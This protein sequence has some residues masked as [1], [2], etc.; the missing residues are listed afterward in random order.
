MKLTWHLATLIWDGTLEGGVGMTRRGLCSGVLLQKAA[1]L[2]GALTLVSTGSVLAQQQLVSNIAQSDATSNPGRSFDNTHL[3]Q[4][5]T[6]GPHAGGYWL[7]SVGLWMRTSSGTTTAA[8]PTV[9]IRTGS[10]TGT[11]EATLTGPSNLPTISESIEFERIFTPPSSLLLHPETTYWIRAEANNQA[12]RWHSTAASAED[13]VKAP[14]WSIA[15]KLQQRVGSATAFSDFG[16]QRALKIRIKGRERR[17]NIPAVGSPV[18]LG[19]AVARQ[20]LS[21]NAFDID[22]ENGLEN[23]EDTGLLVEWRTTKGT[24]ASGRDTFRLTD[25][26]VGGKIRLFIR[27]RDDDG[28]TEEFLTAEYPANG[29]VRAHDDDT[30]S[31]ATGTVTLEGASLLGGTVPVTGDILRPNMDSLVDPDGFNRNQFKFHWI[32]LTPS[33]R[34][35]AAEDGGATPSYLVV[36]DDVGTQMLIRVTTVDEFGNEGVFESAPTEPVRYDIM[37]CRQPDRTGRRVIWQNTVHP[38]WITSGT[39]LTGNLGTRRDLGYDGSYPGAGKLSS[40]WVDFRAGLSQE[41]T[42]DGVWLR[43]HAGLFLVLASGQTLTADDLRKLRLHVCD[44]PLALADAVQQNVLTGQNDSADH[45]SGYRWN[46][47]LMDWTVEDSS[48]EGGI[49]YP[50]TLWLTVPDAP[51]LQSASAN[52]RYVTLAFDPARPLAPNNFPIDPGTAF[53]LALKDGTAPNVVTGIV[54]GH[55]VILTLD[56]AVNADGSGVYSLSYTRPE[57]SLSGTLRDTDGI[58][59]ESFTDKPVQNRSV[60]N[61][62]VLPA[63]SE[64]VLLSNLNLEG[65][66]IGAVPLTDR[67]DMTQAFVTGGHPGGYDLTGIELKLYNALGST[68]LPTVTLYSGSATGMEVATFSGPTV[69]P[70]GNPVDILFTPTAPVAVAPGTKYWVVVEDKPGQHFDWAFVNVTD[71]DAPPAPGWRR[72]GGYGTRAYFSILAFTYEAGLYTQLAIHG[73][74]RAFA[75]GEGT[76][77]G[78][79]DGIRVEETNGEVRVHWRPPKW[80]RHATSYLLYDIRYRIGSGEW[81]DGPQGVRGEFS[82]DQRNGTRWVVLPGVSSTSNLEVQVTARSTDATLSGLTLED[83]KGNRVAL[84]PGFSPQ[85]ESYGAQVQFVDE[86]TITP[87]KNH[88]AAVLEILDG[89]GATLADA[90]SNKTGHQVTL[91]RTQDTDIRIRVTSASTNSQTYTVTVRRVPDHCNLADSTEIWCGLMTVG[92]RRDE[93]KVFLGFDAEDRIGALWPTDFEFR[94]ATVSVSEITFVS[95]GKMNLKFVRTAGTTPSNGLLGNSL[96]VLEFESG[97][98]KESV[99]FDDK[100]MTGNLELNKSNPGLS[101]GDARQVKLFELP[102]ATLWRLEIWDADDAVA[103]DLSPSFSWYTGTYSTSVRHAVDEITIALGSVDSMSDTIEYFDENG[104]AISDENSDALAHQVALSV[105]E[106]T[107]QIKVTST[108]GATRTYTVVVTRAAATSDATLASLLLTE[109]GVSEQLLSPAFT[110]AHETYTVSARH[111]MENISIFAT[112]SDDSAVVEYLN[113][114]DMAIADASDTFDG[115]QAPLSVGSNTIKVKVT[116]SDTATV[117]TYTVTVT[118]EA[119][120][121]NATLDRLLLFNAADDLE[122]VTDQDF[123]WERERFTASVVNTVTEITVTPTTDHASATVA[124]LDDTDSVLADANG[125]KGGHQV[126]LSEGANTIKVRVTAQDGSTM[127]TYTVVVTRLAPALVTNRLKSRGDGIDGFGMAQAF[128]NGANSSGYELD[129][130]V[131]YGTFANDHGATTALHQGSRTGPKVADFNGTNPDLGNLTLTP[132]TEVTL[133]A[134]TTYFIVMSNESRRALWDVT[135]IG[136]E[137]ATPADGWTIVHS[138]EVRLSSGGSWETSSDTF[139]ISVNGRNKVS[140]DATLRVLSITDENDAAVTLSPTFVASTDSYVANVAADITEVTVT[141]TANDTAGTVVYLNRFGDALDDADDMETGHQMAL[142]P[143]MNVIKIKVTAS[144]TTTEKT[145]T[146]VVVRGVA[147][148]VSNAH[149]TVN[150]NA[151]AERSAQAFTTGA[152]ADG[153]TLDRIELEGAFVSGFGNTAT[154]HQT[155]RTGTKV[156]D[157]TSTVPDNLLKYL[158]LAPTTDVTLNASTT[159]V[160]VTANDFST[161]S[162]WFTTNSGDEEFVSATNWAIADSYEW[163]RTGTSSWTTSTG[164][165]MLTVYGTAVS[166]GGG[167]D[168]GGR[169]TSGKDSGGPNAPVITTATT[170]QV[171]ENATRVTKLTATD[172][173]TAVRELVWT[174]AGGDDA[175]KFALTPLGVL[176]FVQAKDFEDPDDTDNNGSYEVTVQASDGEHTTTKDLT[177]TLTDVNEAPVANAGADQTDVPG[178]TPVTL[179]GTGTDPD[180]G[181]T[182]TYGWTKTAGPAVT[183]TDADT[184]TATFVAP[185]GL[186]EDAA[187]SFELTVTD[188]AG[189]THTDTVSVTVSKG[190]ALTA[191]FENA[192]ASHDGSTAFPVRLRFSEEVDLSYQG[193]PTGLLSITGGT[194]GKASRLAPPSNIGWTFPVTPSGNGAVDISLPAHRACSRM[195]GPCTNDGRRLS[196]VASVSIE[197]PTPRPAATLAAGTSPVTEGTAATF[198][199]SLDSAAAAALAVAVTVTE[200]GSMLSGTAPS[201]VAFAAGDQTKTLTLAT[202]DDGVIEA[203]STVTVTLA[204]GTAYTL[205]ATSTASVTVEDNDTATWNVSADATQIA[206]GGSATLTVAVGNGKTFADAQNIALA[207]SGSAD[208]TDFDLTSSPLTLAAGASSVTATLTAIDDTIQESD[209]TVTVTATY[210]GSSIGSATVT[211]QANDDPPAQVSGVTVTAQEASLL[212]AWTAVTGADGYMVQW[213]EDGGTYAATRRSAVAGG[214]TSKTLGDLTAGTL[215]WVQVAATKTGTEQ[216]TWSTEVSGTPTASSSAD[217]EGDLRL[218]GGEEAHEGRIEVYHETEWGTV[219]DDYWGLADAQVACRQLGYSDATEATRRARFGAG[220]GRIWMDDVKCTGDETALAD[221]PFRGWGKTNCGHDEDAGV[222]CTT[223]TDEGESRVTSLFEDLGAPSDGMDAM[224]LDETVQTQLGGMPASELKVLDLTDRKFSDVAGI[225]RLTGLRVLRLRGNEIVDLTPLMGLQ[226]LRELDLSDNAATDLT[227]LA[228]LTALRRLD[229]SDNDVADVSSLLGLPSLAEI[230]LNDN[231]VADIEPLTGLPA[232]ERLQLARNGIS[233]VSALHGLVRLR[234]LDLSGNAVTEVNSLA[235]LSGLERLY[236]AGNTI[237]DLS[238]LAGLSGLQVLDLARN[239][240][241]TLDELTRLHGVRTLKLDRNHLSGLDGLEGFVSLEVLSLRGNAIN[242]VGPLL[243]L[244]NLRW[245]DLRDTPVSDP[246]PLAGAQVV[247]WFGNIDGRTAQRVIL[248]TTEPVGPALPLK[249][250]PTTR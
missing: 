167:G 240:V 28:Y 4:A 35:V 68:L 124:Y 17:V 37:A 12:L 154:L 209:E 207:T 155:T 101:D 65:L 135:A 42:L 57:S 51:V 188:A 14:L 141:P 116:A 186:I 170:L 6:T 60:S 61:E 33:G 203:D 149:Q 179:A 11:S 91:H 18:I 225:E 56:T 169:S 213:R 229:V 15:D 189:L 172:K 166:G 241:L 219:C 90:N 139:K 87:T 121:A 38:A 8:N 23:A 168:G 52:G 22:D 200:S 115:H 181:D 226:G 230:S 98:S 19:P 7:E 246:G 162:D 117:K 231:V 238:A 92:R 86:V 194:I 142:K 237:E 161:N 163:Y 160:V 195:T 94:T 79:P 190:A 66:T 235:R 114:S 96:F 244:P 133:S 112:P 102:A 107:I 239:R 224:T 84:S 47:V 89:S 146:V 128:T 157:F 145:Y 205:G 150:S 41:Y 218:V 132:T 59:V 72:S 97:T 64:R 234:E 199:I 212:V 182:L 178:A 20:T 136:G 21:F 32:R 40:S 220:S 1:V 183:L 43:R 49:P 228:G 214:L 171:A 85:V 3:A 80:H 29:T 193:F 16:S 159:Y 36:D 143:R 223:G 140:S 120:N 83:D 30:D 137:D 147:P 27:L 134:S 130:I 78:Q 69:I 127:R 184:A 129:S 198:T 165:L 63:G 71:S 48:T 99:T 109:F 210:D 208:N 81:I 148:L 122:F 25:D 10:A 53:T 177:V 50:Q 105:G 232:L 233:D 77:A 248:G 13:D 5:F 95:D 221:C 242:D 185:A 2:L 131:L 215:Y 110:S 173:D 174:L 247:L 180:A 58:E 153:Y 70:S 55:R 211:I 88:E 111:T 26:H 206:E 74:P 39:H 34:V 103:G 196:A 75:T 243:K 217:T 158:S 191:A 192:P 164:S 76:V 73:A 46:N 236:L 118:R 151:D 249:P 204:T 54:D 126:A 44:I 175:A 197:G 144:D 123:S 216:G 45:R 152:H 62:T 104:M 138:S 93:R 202:T 156:A 201:S 227:P 119:A 222:V 31:P 108:S 24:G 9:T 125:T 100:G 67:N 250:S 245:L 82:G 113:A 106:N 176:G 187:F